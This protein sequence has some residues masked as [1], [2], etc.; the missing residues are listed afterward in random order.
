MHFGN[1]IYCVFKETPVENKIQWVKSRR[2]K[3][4]TDITLNKTMLLPPQQGSS[5]CYCKAVIFTFFF[6]CTFFIY[7]FIY[8]YFYFT[9]NASPER[10]IIRTQEQVHTN[11][12]LLLGDLRDP[13]AGEIPSSLHQHK[14]IFNPNRNWSAISLKELS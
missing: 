3:S 5:P 9:P 14:N 4:A 6:S 13:G 1:I 10:G 2:V 12:L 7:L 8:Y 11:L